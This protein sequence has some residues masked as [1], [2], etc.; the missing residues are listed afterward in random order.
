LNTLTF[1]DE[2]SHDPTV[3]IGKTD[4]MKDIPLWPYWYD[5]MQLLRPS[6]TVWTTDTERSAVPV[7]SEL[8]PPL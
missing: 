2:W 3:T 4:K 6:G 1:L 5:L 7:P 8:V